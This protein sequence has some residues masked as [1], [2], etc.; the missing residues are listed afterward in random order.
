MDT[1][2]IPEKSGTGM[3]P[4]KVSLGCFSTHS[5]NSVG[6]KPNTLDAL[7]LI[8]SI[9]SCDFSSKFQ[10]NICDRTKQDSYSLKSSMKTS[11]LEKSE[12]DFAGIL[13]MTKK[14]Q[15]GYVCSRCSLTDRVLSRFIDYRLLNREQQK[16]SERTSPQ[17]GNEPRQQNEHPKQSASE[18]HLHPSF[19]RWRIWTD[20]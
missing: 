10:P 2:A 1:Q 6:V 11:S 18:N 20:K 9:R 3:V 12:G 14:K 17:P 13:V 19:D 8:A 7:P 16:P 4:C 15:S 5:E